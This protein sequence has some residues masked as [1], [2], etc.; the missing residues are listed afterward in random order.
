VTDSI[1]DLLR[2]GVASHQSGELGTAERCYRKILE[3]DPDHVDALSLLAAIAGQAGKHDVAGELLVKAVELA[4][5]RADVH[6]NL[7]T[8]LKARGRF[9]EAGAGYRRAL[10]LDGGSVASLVNLGSV[11]LELAEQEDAAAYFRRALDIEPDEFRARMGLGRAMLALGKVGD[12]VN[13]FR[14]ATEL[15]PDSRAAHVQ[16]AR[17][18][19]TDGALDEAVACFRRVLELSPDDFGTLVDL[20][21]ALQTK[22]D[23]GE[24]ISIYR[25]ALGLSPDSAPTRL[26]LASALQAQG[27][28]EDAIG[29]YRKALQVDPD[30]AQAHNNL[31]VAYQI[32]GE[33]EQAVACFR[34]SLEL[35]P[36]NATTSANLANSIRF[37][38]DQQGDIMRMERLLGEIEADAETRSHLHFALGKAY[39]DCQRWDGAFEHFRRAN[40]L[41]GVRFEADK[42]KGLVDG[43]ISI[44]SRELLE[45]GK[46][47]GDASELPIL[48]VGMPRSG[49][50]LVEQILASHPQVHGA[51]ELR[52]IGQ[53]LESLA[54][55]IPETPYPASLE[56]VGP[57]L[58]GKL[59]RKYLS[60]LDA[61]RTAERRVTDK[62]PSNFLQLGLVAMILPHARII[63]CRRQPMDVCLSCF[64][65]DFSDRKGLEF[66]YRLEDLGF[67]YRHYTRLMKHWRKHLPL[68]MLDVD[69]EN[70]V[71]EPERI[72]RELVAFCGLEW[73]PQCLRF[74]ETQRSVAT[75][76]NWQVRQ[77]VYSRSVE[78]WM[79]YEAFLE[80]LARALQD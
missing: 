35:D 54:N 32:Q 3:I 28:L 9:A 78:R 38:D 47:V 40:E 1:S 26:N 29:T 48:I 51:G 18:Y 20:G 5:E 6:A 79:N 11:H 76:S 23:L 30:F 42:F 7:A 66:T 67:Y 36:V 4:P 49:T 44:C 72:S 24:A 41:V 77:P 21:A 59:A 70:L 71:A 22:G 55:A 60:Q 19:R 57:R 52:F 69:Y 45:R 14:R 43:L 64:A 13:C 33:H 25:K 61:L 58:A 63:H 73:S 53:L 75:A 62:M 17:A 31:G 46:E 39:D 16:L 50:S 65:R 80:P 27:K 56:Q 12:A 10:Q 8:S 74:Y 2:Q 68:R 34:R 37:T 15:R